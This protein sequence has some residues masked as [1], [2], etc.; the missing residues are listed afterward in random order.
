MNPWLLLILLALTTFISWRLSRTEADPD[1]AMFN[2]AAFTGSW[3][4]RDW[5]D[6]K[7][8]V[9]HTWYWLI[10]R[11]TGPN[12]ARVKFVNH[13]LIGAAGA[14]F[15][16]L[17]G[18]FIPALIYTIMVNSGWM[19]AFHGNVS[20]IPAALLFMAMA[21]TYPAGIALLVILAV[22]TDPKL[23]PT[24]VAFLIIQAVPAQDILTAGITTGMV[25][26][27][28]ITMVMIAGKKFIPMQKIIGWIWEGSVTI[29]LRMSKNR[30]GL[31]PWMPWWTAKAVLY[32][33]PWLAL[34]V[35]SK[36]DLVYWI[37]AILYLAVISSGQV[38]RQN[39][40]LPL[41]PWIAGAGIPPEF[42]IGLA[43][44]DY[45]SAGF[46]FGDL[47]LRFY[48][49][50]GESIQAAAAVGK[51]LKD[52]PGKLWV[53]GMHT[54]VYI[55]AR[56]PIPYGLA[57][58][59]EIREVAHERRKLMQQRWKKEPAEIVVE[60]ESANVKF[61]PKGY[62][63]MANNGPTRVWRKTI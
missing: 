51:Y 41:I 36:P 7:T 62:T 10:S 63:M 56:R 55:Y 46:Y 17:T 61:S 45:F 34:A 43:G 50:F 40:L 16:A 23:L 15:Y 54:E 57:E 8:P 59:I 52:V 53:N 22:L 26:M 58:Q 39:H 18:E 3:Y 44:L 21:T 11:I 32:I 60:T 6:C 14:A 38:I 35:W 1:W 47:W 42:A 28:A 31:Y 24:G 4:G 37:P 33:G 9:I 27:A 49:G 5:A 20:Q 19:W 12:I 25:C 2:L 29:P 30:G 13:F 48:R